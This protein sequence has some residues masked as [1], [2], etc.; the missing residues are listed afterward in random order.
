VRVRRK[1]WDDS[2]TMLIRPAAIKGMRKFG[3]RCAVLSAAS[4]LFLR[5]DAALPPTAAML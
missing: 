1:R 3:M 4:R 5:R 2:R